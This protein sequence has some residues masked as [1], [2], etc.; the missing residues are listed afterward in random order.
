MSTELLIFV[1]C[2]RDTLHYCRVSGVKLCLQNPKHNKI[3]ETGNMSLL[4][5]VKKTF[6]ILPYIWYLTKVE[7]CGISFWNPL[8]SVS[9]NKV[10][11]SDFFRENLVK[12]YHNITDYSK[13]WLIDLQKNLEF[14]NSVQ[15]INIYLFYKKSVDL[16]IEVQV[17]KSVNNG[18]VLCTLNVSK[19]Q[20]YVPESI[21]QS[22]NRN[23]YIKNY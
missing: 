20:Y 14:C 4:T 23:G 18:R 3:S 22:N 15:A 1:Q 17:S 19:W 12:S 21:F 7:S 8:F 9:Q 6:Y 11:M 16:V 5:S 13:A 10:L 2:W